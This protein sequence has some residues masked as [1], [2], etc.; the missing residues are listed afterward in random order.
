M[1]AFL[2]HQRGRPILFLPAFLAAGALGYFSLDFE[3]SVIWPLALLGVGAAATACFWRHLF[4]RAALLCPTMAAAGCLLASLATARA[5]PWP[6]LP[7]HAAIITGRLA[8]VDALPEGRRITIAAPSL[9]GAPPLARTLRIHLRRGDPVALSPG[10]TVR[11]RALVRQ[12]GPPDYPGGWDTQRDAFFAGLAGYGF[13]IGPAE[14][15]QAASGQWTALRTRIAARI[16]AAL[17][18]P[19][20]PVAATMLTG[21]GTAIAPQDRAAFQDS[22]LAHLLAVA[23][24]HVGI[25]M[26]LAFAATRLILALWERAALYWP[27]RQVAALA[28]LAAGAAYL[29]LTGA[30]V[31]IIRSFAMAALA[32]LGV[33]TGR[34]AVSLRGLALAATI[35][36]VLAP[37]SV[38][39]VSF[40]MSF[41]AV[42]TLVA[43]YEL[44][45]PL[46]ARLRGDAWWAGPALY[47]GGLAL[48]SLLAGTASLPF[49]AYHFGRAT[50]YYV[51]ANMVAVPLTALWVMPWG[52]AALGLMPLGLERLAL[53]PMGWGID[54]LLAIAHAVAAWPGAVVAMRQPPAWGLALVAAGLVWAGLWRGKLR[55]AGLLPLC[56]GLAAP[57][58][59]RAPDMLLTP[60]AGLLAVRVDRRVLVL[61]GRAATPF[62]REAPGRVFGGAPGEPLLAD[63]DCTAQ[64][65]RL[66][67]R[68]R[69]LAVAL[70]PSPIL[71]DAALV[72]SALRLDA[73]CPGTPVLDRASV[74]DGAVEAWLEAGGVSVLSDAAAR[75]VRPWVI[76][77]RSA[78][79]MAP[80]E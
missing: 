79:P 58:L 48:T 30:H 6:S 65:C 50:L 1:L 9:D 3:P 49:A 52:L 18:G 70:A 56:L 62:E 5:P 72:V 20:G 36:L 46:L 2:D 37:D 54:G 66:S 80:T 69:T 31:P 12:P 57:L 47:G 45:R 67:V 10:D 19:A 21:L 16:V 15:L 63:P 42:L 73:R 60:R 32:T 4:V 23:G 78:L 55:L 8:L 25:V 41:A 74:Q 35:L 51:P 59:V 43:G 64:S 14:R 76:A 38:V 27:T 40:Q 53:V 71:C 7:R 29:A 17:P 68:G 13:A 24:L 33:L 34:R 77:T 61:A 75:G 44:A 22:G 39:G 26:G 11:V 28:A